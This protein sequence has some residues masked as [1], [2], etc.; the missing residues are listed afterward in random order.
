MNKDSIEQSYTEFYKKKNYDKVYPTEFVVRTFLA[1][2]PNL[3][4][5]KPE[6]GDSILD[7]GFGDGRN[8]AFL[9]DLGLEVCG[10]EITEEIVSMAYARMIKMGYH[11]DLQ[12]GRNSSIPFANNRFNYILACHSCYYC[13]EGQTIDDNLKEYW[14]VLKPGGWVIASVADMNSFIFNNSKKLPDGTS[15]IEHD[16]YKNRNGYRLQAFESENEILKC[17][18]QYFREF[19]FGHARNDYFGIDERL[20]WVVCKKMSN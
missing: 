20:F 19:S 14:R 16:P 15:R 2:Y 18:S 6:K 11:P 5:K 12:T 4:F 3:N 13:D 7:I 9:C 17:F 8:T 10:I 1:D